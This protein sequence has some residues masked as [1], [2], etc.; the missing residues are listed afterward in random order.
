PISSNIINQ[1]INNLKHTLQITQIVVTHDLHS[2]YTIGDR[3]GL[4]HDGKIHAV[5]TP[6]QI[7]QADDPAVVQFLNG[8]IEGPLSTNETHSTHFAVEPTSQERP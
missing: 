2:A 1:L 3:I 7:Q 5:G 6:E 8:L 4:L